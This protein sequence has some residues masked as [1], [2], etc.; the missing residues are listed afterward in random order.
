MAF[1]EEVAYLRE[2]FSFDGG[3]TAVEE[4]PY[5][6]CGERIAMKKQWRGHCP[7]ASSSP[8]SPGG[9][10]EHI[11]PGKLAARLG[12]RPGDRLIA[13]NDHPL[14]DVI[15]FR[16]YGSEEEMELLIEREGRRFTL[17]AQREYGE[18]WGV[19]FAEPVFD[20]IRWCNNRCEFCFV[21][22]MPPGMRKSLYVKD[23]DYRYSFLFGNFIT[24]T[25]LTEEDWERLAEQRLSPL[26]VSVH[27]TDLNLRRELLGN[28]D[29]PDVLEQIRRLG[30]LGIE[31]HTQIVL[32]P[33]R[34][35]GP[36]LKRTIEDLSA[37]YPTV[38]SIAVVPVG[39]TRFQ[40]HG[41]RPYSPSEAK[42]VVAQV[43]AY[44]A[45]FR[46][47]YEIGL[48]YLSD[49][50]YFMCDLPLP[51]AEEYDGFPQ[52]ENGVGLARAF[53][54]DW[55]SE[56][57]G[58]RPTT[59]EATVVCGTMPYPLIRQVMEEFSAVTGAEVE[60]VAVENRFFGPMVTVSGLLTGQDVVEALRGKI[61]TET[62]VLPRA[63]FDAEGKLTLDDMTV[64]DI[65]KAL[66][67]EVRVA[68]TPGQ[69]RQP[70]DG[71]ASISVVHHAGR[72]P[73][74]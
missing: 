19:E 43:I 64:E 31:V 55:E 13:I 29:A 3:E 60:V 24:L 11:E 67:V 5:S 9:L 68:A 46:K 26:Y 63:M 16:F 4:A 74:P 42:E 40:R 34:N 44:Q 59:L 22:Q 17:K 30:E 69:C 18:E 73:H 58:L 23:D 53:L 20:G 14:R 28:P 54:E 37:L 49:E 35:D 15:D 41:I 1:S 25:N 66:G 10:I 12:L 47:F 50:W 38:Q 61:A 70:V 21:N 51:A 45:H 8:G 6:L 72:H 32:I 33:G 57:A 71:F 39:V 52:L 65:E 56:K 27:S 2:V 36:H 48:V 7:E 62:L